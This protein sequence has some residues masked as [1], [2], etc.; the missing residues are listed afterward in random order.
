MTFKKSFSPFY[1]ILAIM[2]VLSC[3]TTDTASELVPFTASTLEAALVNREFVID[4][5]IACAGSNEDP[6][7]T[8]VFVYPREGVTNVRY[9]ETESFE[10]DKND[11]SKYALG[12][13]DAIDVFNGFLIKYEISPEQEK[14]V[15]VSFEEEGMV[16]ISNPIRL[17]QFTKPTEYLPEN[18]TVASNSTMPIFTWQDGTFEDTIIYFHVVSNTDDDLL[19]GTYTFDK[20]FQYYNLDNVVLNITE[21]EPPS[22]ETDEDYNFTLLSVSEDNWVNQ[23]SEIS[24]K[25]Q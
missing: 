24:F 9:Y 5:V 16:H 20:T 13:A 7:V 22:L 18:I 23:F 4:N 2:T 6:S 3:S 14:W 11:Y 12:E 25:V 8:S 21:E 15:I 1:A 17:K 19:S 10:D